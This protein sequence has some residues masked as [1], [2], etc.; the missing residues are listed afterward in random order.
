[1]RPRKWSR[2]GG[3]A[4]PGWE[5]VAARAIR[6]GICALAIAV[7][8]APTSAAADVVLDWNAITLATIRNQNPFAQAR[9]AAIVQLAVFE[10][11]NAA[12]GDYHPYLGTTTAPAG[13]SAA[14][15]AVAAAH[16]VLVTY[17]PIAAPVLDADRAAS[18]AAIPDGQAKADG[19]ATGEA[20]ADAIMALRANDGSAPPA[21]Y[22]P[23]SSAA[24]EWQ[25]TR[26][27]SLGG[28]L[29]LHWAGVAPFALPTAAAFRA[30]APPALASAVY[31]KDYDEVRRVGGAD[32]L[33]RPDDRAEVARFYG[34]TTGSAVWNSAARQVAAAQGRAISHNAWA[35]ALLNMAISDSLVASFETKYYYR[36]WRPETAI[37]D[38]DLDGNPK[39]DADA[40]FAPFIVTPCFP[41]YPS[42]HASS[43]YAALEV[44]THVYDGG[45]HSV[46][47]FNPNVPDVVLSYS[48]FKAIAEDI[49]D[50]RVYGGIHFRFDQEGGARQGKAVG[51]YVL[52]STLRSVNAPD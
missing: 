8:V 7:P 44:L 48:R 5:F 18:L 19:I 1:M 28:G 12:T 26:A 23:V 14:A 4:V 9:L 52:R 40:S 10:A 46:V 13:A 32:S 27:C 16:K 15:A 36:L 25:L 50:A 49:D 39:T 17:F 21:L 31:A 6:V 43:A 42:A 37:H 22:F 45:G 2:C 30:P 29:F 34:L 47:L 11:V 35:L 24:G 33:E 3:T 41:S 51:A 38:G 20:A